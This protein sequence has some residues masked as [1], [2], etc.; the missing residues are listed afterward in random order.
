MGVEGLTPLD[1]VMGVEGVNDFS[2]IC[3]C[4]GTD[5]SVGQKYENANTIFLWVDVIHT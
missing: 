5:P 3:L 4:F 1:Q 2:S